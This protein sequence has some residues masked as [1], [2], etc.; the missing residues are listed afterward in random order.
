MYSFYSSS[1]Y[2]KGQPGLKSLRSMFMHLVMM[3]C[4]S[5][6]RDNQRLT[7]ANFTYYLS[8]FITAESG[9]SNTPIQNIY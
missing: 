2:P 1:C 7:K 4:A 6:S 8:D 3:S 5:F 9:S